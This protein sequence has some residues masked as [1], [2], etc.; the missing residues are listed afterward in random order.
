MAE[1]DRREYDRQI[2][3]LTT[4]VSALKDAV[5]KLTAKVDDLT[6]AK[7]QGIG[8]LVAVGAIGSLVGAFV[9]DLVKH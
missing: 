3:V 9:G 7:N 2:A 1:L 5:E 6:A 4:Q 8:I